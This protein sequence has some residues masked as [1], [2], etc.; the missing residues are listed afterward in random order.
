MEVL[1]VRLRTGKAAYITLSA[2]Q[3]WRRHSIYPTETWVLLHG[4]EVD[5]LEPCSSFTA[6]MKAAGVRV[7][8]LP[9]TVAKANE[10]FDELRRDRHEPDPKSAEAA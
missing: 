4:H 7:H 3:A 9:E 8:E 10:G 5:V 1:E 2:I 6:R